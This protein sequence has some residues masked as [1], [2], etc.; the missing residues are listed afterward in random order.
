MSYEYIDSMIPVKSDDG[1]WENPGKCYTTFFQSYDN[2]P[3]DEQNTHYMKLE[4]D[5][6]V[7]KKRAEAHMA[8]STTPA[9]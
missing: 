3:R 5:I 2:Y 6:E 7:K 8:M 4:K 1:F 9:K